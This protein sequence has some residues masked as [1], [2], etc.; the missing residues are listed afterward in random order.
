MA[1]GPWQD[2]LTMRGVGAA[3]GFKPFLRGGALA[4]ACVLVVAA[5]GA[6]A[7]HA[8]EARLRQG[9]GL[10]VGVTDNVDLEPDDAATSAVTSTLSH[11]ARFS[12]EGNRLDLKFQS[13]VA[14]ETESSQGDTTVDQAVR[15]VGNAEIVEDWFFL[16][17]AGSS[18]RELVNNTSGISASGRVPEEDRATVNIIEASPYIARTLGSYARGELRVRHTEIFVSDDGTADADLEDRRIDEQQLVLTSGPRLQSFGLRGELSHLD[19]REV[20]DNTVGENDVEQYQ[21]AVTAIYPVTRLF[22]VLA[23]VG[24]TNVDTNDQRDLSGPLW[25]VGFELRGKRL[26]GVATVGRRYNR[27]RAT[28]DAEYRATAKTRLRAQLTR[29]L[30]TS[31]GAIATLNRERLADP[32]EDAIFPE[33]FTGDVEE[34][35]ALS[36]RGRL[37]AAS[38]IG[39]NQL[40][41]VFG[42]ADREF[43]DSS[44]QTF[45]GRLSWERSLARHWRARVNLLGRRTTDSDEGDASLVGARTELVY[46]IS[47]SA[48]AFVGFSRTDQVSDVNADEYTENVAFVGGRIRF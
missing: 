27:N 34:G 16:D 32:A 15:G 39:R 22:A 2:S 12:L 19:S 42:F 17:V 30:E 40:R 33:D 11:N 46:A 18:T 21:G 5:A 20:R 37:E 43:V 45:T 41:L 10:E 8:A 25:D 47:R 14:V 4:A 36:W 31:Q 29:A 6:Q 24:G 13:D 7:A 3:A 44:D 28:L 48:E 1:P 35:V 26:T 38:R 23:T 9:A